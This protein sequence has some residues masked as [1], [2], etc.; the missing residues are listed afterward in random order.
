MVLHPPSPPSPI[1]KDTAFSTKMQKYLAI[2]Q[3]YWKKWKADFTWT[4]MFH[5][6]VHLRDSPYTSS[7][8]SKNNY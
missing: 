2:Q 1:A 7:A 5:L 6:R 8:H 4:R 3:V